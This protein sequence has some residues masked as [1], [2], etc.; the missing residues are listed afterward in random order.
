MNLIK[1]PMLSSDYSAFAN[2]LIPVLDGLN[3][4][5]LLLQTGIQPYP[6]DAEFLASGIGGIGE[7]PLIEVP[8]D[9]RGYSIISRLIVFPIL[10]IP[11]NFRPVCHPNRIIGVTKGQ[12]TTI[13]VNG[14]RE[15]KTVTAKFTE[16]RTGVQ[17][18]ADVVSAAADALGNISV[19]FTIPTTYTG[20]RVKVN[21][22]SL[23]VAFNE[24]TPNLV[25]DEIGTAESVYT[26]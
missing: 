25:E 3:K 2:D 21:Y 7:R 26:C 22:S 11:V 20:T 13:F 9:C 12:S 5:Q 19:T 6:N 1:V 18:T 15:G 14:I 8:I 16:P 4:M 24:V 23:A 10:K 17:V